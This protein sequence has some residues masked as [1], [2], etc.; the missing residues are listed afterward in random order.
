[1]LRKRFPNLLLVWT[2]A[3]I[4]FGSIWAPFQFSLVSGEFAWTQRAYDEPFYLWQIV[5]SDIALNP[6]FASA[7]LVRAMAA[8]AFSFDGMAEAYGLLLPPAVFTAALVLASTWESAVTRR[9]VWALLLFLSFDLFSGSSFVVFDTLPAAALADAIGRPWLL[10]ADP[11]HFFIAYRRPEPQTSWV[12]LLLYFSGL[13]RSFIA[14]RP[15]LYAVVCVATPFLVTLHIN[16]ALIG[17]LAFAL[18]STVGFVVYRRPILIRLVGA[19]AATA[20]AFVVLFAVTSRPEIAARTVTYTHIPLLRPSLLISIIVLVAL[21]VV[22][23]RSNSAPALPQH[24]AA[25]VFLSIPIITLEQQILTGRAVLAQGWEIYG[26]YICLVIGVALTVSARRSKPSLEPSRVVRRSFLVI[27]AVVMVV[28]LRG[29]IRNEKIYRQANADSVA[30][31]RTYAQAVRK[32]GSIDGV[33]L[34][35]LFDESLFV[36]RVPKSTRVLGGFNGLITDWPPVWKVDD[37][38]RIHALNAAKHF[39]LGFEVLARQGM[40]VSE[41]RASLNEE[42][43]TGVAWPTLM[44]FFSL[45][46]CWPR[47]SNHRAPT[48]ARLTSAVDP[49]VSLYEEYLS[50]VPAVAVSR[51]VMLITKQ[52]L[53]EAETS[54]FSHQ[55]VATVDTTVGR[56]KVRVYAYLQGVR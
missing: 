49:L 17:I 16:V 28:L 41:L 8:V 30:Y 21:A 19:L 47:L 10:S 20:G 15:R 3:A 11:M 4:L 46:D 32:T 25:A 7:L 35:H 1:M 39:D 31:A 5:T 54:Q 50:H 2:Y 34:P 55:L 13:L 56:Y 44:Y 9:V 23:R 27:W 40:T 26:N 6:N 36:T 42:I 12:F 22:A 52:L 43:R 24:W 51:R 37:N 33:V 38:F 14:W 45:Q 48:F 29:H 18:L 53:P